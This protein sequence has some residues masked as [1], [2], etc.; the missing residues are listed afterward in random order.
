M[1]KKMKRTK[2]S[3][4]LE[5]LEPFE[6]RF[7]EELKWQSYRIGGL[8]KPMPVVFKVP[9]GRKLSADAVYDVVVYHRKGSRAKAEGDRPTIDHLEVRLYPQPDESEIQ[10]ELR[11]AEC[12]KDEDIFLRGDK[13]LEVIRFESQER[14]GILYFVPLGGNT[15]VVAK[16][17]DLEVLFSGPCVVQITGTEESMYNCVKVVVQNGSDEA[18]IIYDHRKNR[19]SPFAA[20]EHIRKTAGKRSFKFWNIYDFS[21][22]RNQIGHIL[23]NEGLREIA[24]EREEVT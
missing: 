2:L 4:L 12:G 16:K 14:K 15:E 19:W 17:E 22:G 23:T 10:A 13:P 18:M 7:Y 24:E 1:K 21:G 20:V 5:K 8:N 3:T 9:L 11:Y 6:P